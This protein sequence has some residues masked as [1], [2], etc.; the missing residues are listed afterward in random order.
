MNIS[1]QTLLIF[2]V[3]FWLFSSVFL[4]LVKIYDFYLKFQ[5]LQIKNYSKINERQLSCYIQF[6][7]DRILGDG[8]FLRNF[9]ITPSRFF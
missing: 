1:D 4:F 6:Q 3:Q 5:F 7:D 2:G 8:I 9:V